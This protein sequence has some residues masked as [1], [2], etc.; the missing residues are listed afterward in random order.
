MRNPLAPRAA[1]HLLARRAAVVGSSAILLLVPFSAAAH[2][3]PVTP[4]TPGQQNTGQLPAEQ[5]PQGLVDAIA[6]DL[7][8]SPHEYLERASRAQEL[9][10]YAKNFRAER[11][12]DFAGA[13]IGLDGQPVVA[14]TSTDAAA[15]A[16][17]DGYKT[18]IAAVSADGLDQSL[19]EI[20]RW[21]ATLPRELATQVNGA[22]IDV[23][24]NQVV[25]DILNSPIGRALNLPTVIANVQV[26]L[27]PGVPPNEPGPLGGDTYITAAG[28]LAQT[29][30]EQI[31]VCSFGFNAVDATGGA[32]NV[33][34]G[35]CNPTVTTG[36]HSTV[37]LPNREN[38]GASL[39]I[40]RFARS[41]VGGTSGL[42]YGVISLDKAGV[43]AGLNRPVIRGG[44]GSTL[45]VTGT[46]IPV[47]GAP[48]CKSGQTSAF[49]CGVVAA[50]RVETQL[51][52]SDGSSRTVRGFAASTCTLA[53]DS[54]GAIVTGTL[55]LGITSG[56]NSSMAP[57][58]AEA[59]LVLAPQGGTMSL[60]IPIRGIEADTGARVRTSATA[61]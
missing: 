28:P 40:G 13:W 10:S 24:N 3:E 19:D 7:K 60:G 5:L 23:F 43:D 44:N 42:D 31:R 41:N 4:S 52:V 11:P 39:P 53:G 2:A 37:Y 55:A 34:A 61:D 8:I 58:C 29:P 48:I 36:G 6:R 51:E 46:A 35:H 54:G 30:A 27:T 56:S 47:V 57:N 45:T 59:N 20:N 18:T 22:S 33:T 16:A 1:M 25:V 26:M 38:V 32:V 50:D 49:T 12:A 15:I 14:V 9:G 17:R 21:V